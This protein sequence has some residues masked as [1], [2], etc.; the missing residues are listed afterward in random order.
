MN[1]GAIEFSVGFQLSIGNSVVR[2]KKRFETPFE[3]RMKLA[4][5]TSDNI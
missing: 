4:V 1:C 3:S 2:R 5:Q